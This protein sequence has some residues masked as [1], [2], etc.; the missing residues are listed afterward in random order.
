MKALYNKKK[1]LIK[2]INRIGWLLDR[3]IEKKYGFH[4]SQTDDD[5]MIDTLD[6][7]TQDLSYHDFVEKMNEFKKMKESGEWTPND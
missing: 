5:E 7:G 1:K 6:Y 4:Y 3:E 2:Q